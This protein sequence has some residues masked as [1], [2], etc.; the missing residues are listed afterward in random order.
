VNIQPYAEGGGEKIYKEQ[1]FLR[2]KFR[3]TTTKNQNLIFS[4]AET[5]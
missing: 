4:P 5:M 2:E 1:Y 3:A